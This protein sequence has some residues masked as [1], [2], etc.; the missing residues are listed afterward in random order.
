MKKLN[1]NDYIALNSI[2]LS[3]EMSRAKL[4][5]ILGITA[6][7]VFKIVKKLTEK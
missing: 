2:L 5:D 4:V 1:H 6:P 7:A 3:K